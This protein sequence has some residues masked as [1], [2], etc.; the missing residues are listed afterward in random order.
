MTTAHGLNVVP[1]DGKGLG[2]R[3]AQNIES[4]AVVIQE[5]PLL[6]AFPD[7]HISQ[8]L[9]QDLERELGDDVCIN[10]CI[11]SLSFFSKEAGKQDSEER[12]AHAIEEG[13]PGECSSA[14]E[15]KVCVAQWIHTKGNPTQRAVLALY[16]VDRAVVAHAEA[17]HRHRLDLKRI[18]IRHS[19]RQVLN[20]K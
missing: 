2:V 18:F 17:L 14:T 3:A 6:L 9:L 16:G 19:E 15:M 1:V 4:K 11:H 12:S 13:E 7:D 5:A 10:D 8:D 20:I